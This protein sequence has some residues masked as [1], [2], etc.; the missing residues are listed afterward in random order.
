MKAEGEKG[1][2]RVHFI[3]SESILNPIAKALHGDNRV[4][5]GA[6]G[7]PP[8]FGLVL[9]PRLSPRVKGNPAKIPECRP[10]FIR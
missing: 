9:T 10:G 2:E 6:V 8:S 4:P 1:F 3:S 7:S 5:V